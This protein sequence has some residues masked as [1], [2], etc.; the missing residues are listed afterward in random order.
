MCV[1]ED[2]DCVSSIK[3]DTSECL[4]QC[5]GIMVTSK[6]ENRLSSVVSGIVEY[7]RKNNRGFEEIAKEFPGSC[8]NQPIS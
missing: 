7:F 4:Q 2:L 6:T 1:K 5:S 3:V 8:L